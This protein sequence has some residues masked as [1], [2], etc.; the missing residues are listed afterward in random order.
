MPYC[1]NMHAGVVDS[2]KPAA[3][4]HL[5]GDNN[6]KLNYV[7]AR[8]IWWPAAAIVRTHQCEAAPIGKCIWIYQFKEDWQAREATHHWILIREWHDMLERPDYILMLGQLPS[9]WS[10]SLTAETKDTVI[11]RQHAAIMHHHFLVIMVSPEIYNV[12]VTII[13]SN[14]ETS[15]SFR[16]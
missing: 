13:Y 1:L 6:G 14:E 9:K 10:R 12:W 15:R 7:M 11:R 8:K 4:M 5:G 3:W 2:L 16:I